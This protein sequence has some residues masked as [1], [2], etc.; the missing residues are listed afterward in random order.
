MS[1]INLT[2]MRLQELN[3]M[4]ISIAIDDFG[5]GHSSLNYL[6]HLPINTLKIDRSFVKGCTK[7]RHDAEII[8]AIIT[9]AHSLDLK[10]IAEGVET[11]DQLQYVTSLGCDFVQGFLFSQPVGSEQISAYAHTLFDIPE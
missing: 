11:S 1:N 5:T 2:T 10:V 4:G 8:K 3:T 9:I 6:K 7:D